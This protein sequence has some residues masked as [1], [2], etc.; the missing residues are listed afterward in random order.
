[1]AVYDSWE[2]LTAAA[3]KHCANVLLKDVA[4][5][6]K[7]I[8]RKHIQSDIYD[9]YTP[10]EGAWVNGST[11]QRRGKLLTTLQATL[12]VDGNEL[13][14]TS[15][16]TASKPII[17]GYRFNNVYPGAFL[18]M[19]ESDNRGIWKSGFPR[20]AISNAQ[21]EIDSSR[22]IISAIENGFRR[23]GVPVT[24]RG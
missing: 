21:K 8:V 12:N 22:E 15:K 3:E 2:N 1:M 17:K 18:E 11:Y 20:P 19:L 9:A 4:P 16:A 6:A 7:E 14:V 10:Q 23:R 5:V 24:Y 13:T